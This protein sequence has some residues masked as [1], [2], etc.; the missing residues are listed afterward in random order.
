MISGNSL[1]LQVFLYLLPGEF[2]M[3]GGY[4]VRLIQACKQKNVFDS[5][6]S[7]NFQALLCKVWQ[8]EVFI[9]VQRS[10]RK[11]IQKLP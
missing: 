4:L 1:T 8:Q 2:Q 9:S 11:A 7:S 5:Y 6:L 3:N 10:R